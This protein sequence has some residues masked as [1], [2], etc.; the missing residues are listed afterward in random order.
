MHL[1]A[2]KHDMKSSRKERNVDNK[3]PTQIGSVW[4][5]DPEMVEIGCRRELINAD[6]C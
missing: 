4:H 1:V 2:V 6:I 5:S 3:L